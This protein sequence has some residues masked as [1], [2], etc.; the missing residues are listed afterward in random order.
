MKQSEQAL[1]ITLIDFL[2]QI[3]FIGLVIGV[4]YAVIQTENDPSKDNSQKLETV[5]KDSG[6]NVSELLDY[7]TD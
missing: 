4:V 3:I 1:Y 7:L 6:M 5:A 2:I